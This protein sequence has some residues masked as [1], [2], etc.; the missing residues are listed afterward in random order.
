MT[1]EHRPPAKHKTVRGAL[2]YVADHPNLTTPP[3][4]TP[5]WHL[6]ALTLFEIANSPDAR[7]K[8]SLT[9]ASRAQ[10]MIADRL[11]G[12][13]RRGTHPATAQEQTVILKD[14]TAGVV[15]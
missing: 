4:D 11:V 2:Q 15:R 14:L 12:L 6:I 5:V 10:R 1:E 7:V 3:I 13:R 9:R 8:G